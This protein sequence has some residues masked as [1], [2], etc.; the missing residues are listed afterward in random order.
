MLSICITVKDRSKY[1]LPNG[2]IVELL[3]D[4]LRSLH[5]ANRDLASD[6]EVVISDFQSKDW[7][8]NEWI[9]NV[10]GDI[11]HTIITVDQPFHRGLGRNIAADQANGDL[12]FFLDA[13]ML[14]SERI[15]DDGIEF[16]ERGYIYYPTCFY[17][18]NAEHSLGY[19]CD[20]GRGNLFISRQYYLDAGK[21][22]CPPKFKRHHDEDQAFFRKIKSLNVPIKIQRDEKLLHQYHPGRAI[23]I[24]LKRRK[25]LLRKVVDG[26]IQEY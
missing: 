19:W 5:K 4:C 22:P 3:P 25:H 15:L 20:G 6:I 7:P 9:D 8:L 12:L 2:K 11:E 1:P 16:L 14:L 23:E 18:L 13:D 21:W 24:G 26:E 10:L 17:F